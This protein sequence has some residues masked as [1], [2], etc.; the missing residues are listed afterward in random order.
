MRTIVVGVD[1]SKAG[2]V[3]LRWAWDEAR[4]WNARLVAI[5]AWER[6]YAVYA[7]PVGYE[8]DKAIL[9]TAAKELMT[10]AVAR[11]SPDAGSFV[12]ERVV[13]GR[14]ADALLDAASGADLLVVGSRDRSTFGRL[15]LGSVSS[16]CVHHSPCTVVVVRERSE[17][18]AAAA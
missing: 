15:L 5:H 12:E 18:E 7:T 10:D 2:D 4:L 3:A 11:A 8:V 6:P 9:E 13:R 16:A 14:A 17:G 1:G